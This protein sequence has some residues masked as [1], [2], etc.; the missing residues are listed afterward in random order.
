[1]TAPS[2]NFAFA[3][4]RKKASGRYGSVGWHTFRHSYRSWLDDSG[5]PVGVQRK[6]MR[7]AQVAATMNV[8]GNALMEAKR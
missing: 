7:H 1:L 5:A 4:L 8:Y 3:I 2:Y 6:L